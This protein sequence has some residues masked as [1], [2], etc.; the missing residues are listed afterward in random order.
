MGVSADEEKS[1]DVYVSISAG[2][3]VGSQETPGW[4]ATD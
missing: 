4:T 2:P 1:G 3:M